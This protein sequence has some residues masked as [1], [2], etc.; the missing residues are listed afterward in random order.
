VERQFLKG[1]GGGGRRGRSGRGRGGSGVRGFSQALDDL[2]PNGCGGR[3]ESML[4]GRRRYRQMDPWLD[5][6]LAG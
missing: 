2:H 3:R 4:K 6:L 5:G 1:G